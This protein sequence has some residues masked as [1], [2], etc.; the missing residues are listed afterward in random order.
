EN[1]L[2]A[3][4]NIG[5][6]S[7]KS[8]STNQIAQRLQTKASSATDMIKR[9]SEKGLVDY[10]KYQGVSLTS[11][12][13]AIA[14][15][16]IRSHR[17]WEYFLVNHLDY[18]WDEVHELAEQLEHIKSNSLIEKLDTFLCF[19]TH[20]P[21][22]DPIPDKD[23]RIIP[24]KNTMLSSLGEQESGMVVGVK[25]S[26]P[27]LLQLLD[28]SGIKLGSLIKIIRQEAFDLSMCVDLGEGPLSISH[29]VSKNLYVTKS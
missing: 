12:G 15:S 1:Y 18:N 7:G 9:L 6:A 26:S 20:D 27:E 8:V 13:K 3:I 28:H 24:H 29:Q 10:Q 5:L 14:V 25:D 16:T 19:P 4:Y 17:L 11:K 23:G 2:K 22:G 21:H